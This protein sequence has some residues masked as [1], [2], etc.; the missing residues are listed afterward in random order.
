MNDPVTC[1]HERFHG[2]VKVIRLTDLGEFVVELAVRCLDCESPFRFVGLETAIATDRP[3]VG[4]FGDVAMLPI[5]PGRRR[6]ED[7][8]TTIPITMR[9]AAQGRDV[10]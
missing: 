5:L 3:C 7:I 2:D 9:R 8:P 10:S 4:A 1:K 6:L